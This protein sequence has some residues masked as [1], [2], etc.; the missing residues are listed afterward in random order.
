MAKSF[1]DKLTSFWKPTRNEPMMSDF[2]GEWFTSFGPMTLTQ[3]G[4]RVQGVY[5]PGPQECSLEGT[6]QDGVLRFRYREP[7]ATG[8]GW[9]VMQRYGKF[10][11][12]WRQDGF[13]GWQPWQGE[14]GFEGLWNSTFGPLRLIQGQG[15]VHGYYEG[16]GSSSL[17]GRLDGK[18]L[19]FR[20]KE[21]RAQGDG[22]FELTDNGFAFQGQW[23]P[24][25][26][27]A[28]AP[29]MGQRIM[30]V[31]GLVWLVVLEAY[32][33]HGLADK[34]Y[35]FG[36]ML[37]EFFA[38]V[39]RI[40]VRQRFFNNEA[41]LA[42]WCRELLFLAEPI[43]LVLAT[44]G[45]SEGL[46]AH[47]ELI[48]AEPI[49]NIL[50]DADNIQVLHF[51][52]CLLMDNGPAGD[53]ARVLRQ[54]LRFPIS[55][56]TTSVDWAASALI[57]FTYLDMILARGLDPQTAAKQVTQ[58][59]AFAGDRPPADS[60]YPAAHFTF[61]QPLAAKGPTVGS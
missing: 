49:A 13:P 25:G 47:G 26:A 14:R 46:T 9:F 53:F 48:R 56:Y 31:P 4:L 52:S 21:P 51:S 11:G 43:A 50:R 19:A 22:S 27:A 44:H 5:G 45:T 58:L 3:E 12:Q 6:T 10:S 61:W 1:W 37:R 30:P 35:A 2:A 29:W 32:W 41:G 59:L 40:E 8:E 42:K 28:Y 55:G 18:R 23:R 38:R 7:N 54:E 20:Y 15:E 36:N 17:E 60:P 24:D 57:E 16:L 39:P 34:E 33:Q